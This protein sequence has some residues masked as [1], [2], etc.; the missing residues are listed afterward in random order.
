MGKSSRFL[1]ILYII[2][3]SALAYYLKE[4][5]AYLSL[6]MMGLNMLIGLD[7]TLRVFSFKRGIV[8]ILISFL[9]TF[10]LETLSMKSGIP[11]GYFRYNLSGPAIGSVPLSVCFSYFPLI[12][13]GW[14]FGDLAVNSHPVSKSGGPLVRILFA[15]F[16]L[17]VIDLLTA[18][19]FSLILRLW[20]YPAGGGFYSIP[21]TNTL[22]WMA[23]T[24]LT[25]IIFE[26]SSLRKWIRPQNRISKLYCPVSYLLLA[27]IVPIIICRF[28]L[29]NRIVSDSTGRGW[30]LSE[31]YD[32]L[33][34]IG[35]ISTGILFLIGTICWETYL[36]KGRQITYS[37]NR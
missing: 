9:V 27:Q 8:L 30:N 12:T 11:Y 35:L 29:D 36:K 15:M 17:S 33:S 3:T 22:G 26:A 25:L 37:G 13:I 21:V 4:D 32:A 28:A 5:A 16:T 23:N 20:D 6:V 31:L 7:W 14:V 18:P 10:G 19:V 2:C 1:F 24:A 34:L